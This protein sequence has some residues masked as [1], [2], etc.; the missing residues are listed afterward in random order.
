M[1]PIVAILAGGRSQRMGEP[2]PCVELGGKPLISYPI[3]AAQAAGL[4]S[5][6]VA[7][8]NS[9]LPSSDCPVLIEPDEPRHPLLGVVTAL[10]A[11]RPAPVIALG[12]DM[13]FLTAELLSR[14]GAA[15]T[16]AAV[17]AEGRLQPLLARY[18]S[19]ALEPLERAL[20]A[21]EP[22]TAALK[23]LDPEVIEVEGLACFNVNSP[24]DLERAERLLEA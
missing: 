1:D 5:W 20:A 17:E 8:G 13:P 14:L 7:K 18:D 4:E 10:R 23:G 2:K 24:T 21:G 6:I 3:A 12:A 15:E 16:T 22:A 9:E 19:G 11:A